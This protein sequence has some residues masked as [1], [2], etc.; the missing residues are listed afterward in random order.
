MPTSSEKQSPDNP[1]LEGEHWNDLIAVLHPKSHDSIE[2]LDA[3]MSDQL[4]DLETKLAE[5]SS[6]RSIKKALRG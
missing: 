6:N 1:K 4:T 5:F 2:S 3:W